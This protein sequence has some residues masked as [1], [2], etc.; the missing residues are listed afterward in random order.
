VRVT[1]GTFNLNNLFSRFN[2]A[3]AIDAIQ[4]G[5]SAGGLTIRYELTDPATYRIRT[6]LGKLV[7]AK[8]EPETDA[9]ARRILAMDID[10]LAVQEVEDIDSL[11]EFNR[12]HLKGLYPHYLKSRPQPAHPNRLPVH[13]CRSPRG[14]PRWPAS[15]R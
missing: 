4:S 11:K 6:F 2:F 12:N 1:V 10:A 13:G 15:H 9:V 8:D 14:M 3:G 5:G 7:R